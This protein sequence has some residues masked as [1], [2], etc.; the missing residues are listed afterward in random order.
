MKKREFFLLTLVLSIFCITGFANEQTWFQ[1]ARPVW[2]SGG[3]LTQNLT[4]GLHASFDLENHQS[5]T[6]S[7]TAASSYKAYLNGEFIGFGPSITAH[8][9]FRVDEYD[10]SQKLK[11]GKNV[12]AIVAVG[13]NVDSYYI[14]NQASFVQA[15]LV[16]DG[17]VI[18]ATSSQND[19]TTIKLIASGQR[20]PHVPKFSFQRTFLE[21]Y[22]LKPDFNLWITSVK[23]EISEYTEKASHGLWKH[24][25][26]IDFVRVSAEETER[27]KLL[28]RKVK[29]PDYSI[30]QYDKKLDK[31]IY[32]FDKMYTG[33]IMCKV[34]V[35][36][37][38]TLSLFFE[39]LLIDGDINPKRMGLNAFVKYNL[40][41]G[42][43]ALESYEPYSLKYLKPVIDNGDCEILDIKIRQYANSDVSQIH[44]DSDN[45]NIN[46]IFEAAK[47]TH[48]QNALDIFMDC[49]SRERAGW[50][51]DSYFSARVAYNF[52]GNTL[53]ENNFIE[54]FLLPDKF[55]HIPD[56]MLPMCYP[57]DHTNGNFIPNWAM[58]FVLQLEEYQKR[59]G[60]HDMVEALKPKVMA[61]MDYF[62][63]F[64]NE[65]GLLEN[66][67]KWV[68]VEWSAANRFVQDVNYPTN[69]LYAQTLDV[70]S[71]LYDLP[72]YADEAKK[73]RNTIRGQALDGTFFVDNAI[74][75]NGK[76]EPQANNKTEVCQYYAFYF[77]VASSE[78]DPE[79]YDF[80]TKELTIENKQAL[81]RHKIHP[82]NAFIGNYLRMEM[83]SQN[84]L[85]KQ[86]L[87]EVEKGFLYMA[88]TTGTL[89]EHMNANASCNHG[90]AAHAGFVLLRDFAGF[91]SIDQIKKSIIIQFNDSDMNS[92]EATVPVG[93]EFIQLNWEKNGKKLIYSIN[94]PDQYKIEIRNNTNFE[95]ER[96]GS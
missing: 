29:Y 25:T 51:C 28:P 90:F 86:L 81:E 85:Q 53:I 92:C 37:P 1:K 96:T 64:E 58:W 7:I 15:E 2:A 50:L 42:E 91:H 57:A 38:T 47:E 30:K 74:R 79:L 8:G 13:Y 68:F 66:L 61:L 52:S 69:M 12:L 14:P 44:F 26:D 16:V 24:P 55:E 60:D 20:T 56:G 67:E 27:K 54:N 80:L 10:L 45:P 63:R 93:Q 88:E 65:Y 84:N 48:K 34:K 89:W 62:K 31:D 94:T 23:L 83:L 9:Y 33:F 78:R 19:E 3:Q 11:S 71:R 32:A 22:T 40:Q 75:N 95:L 77:G 41:A 70:V 43:Y 36:E 49:P 39:E 4:I 82:C 6:F 76:L 21:E 17:K 18:A 5:A 72:N 73:L 46:L 87:D 35:K 59:S